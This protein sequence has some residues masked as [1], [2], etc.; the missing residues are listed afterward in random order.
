MDFVALDEDPCRKWFD[1]ESGQ[2]RGGRQQVKAPGHEGEHRF[3]LNIRVTADRALGMLIRLRSLSHLPALL[4]C[5]RP[6]A[7][8]GEDMRFTVVMA[9]S[10][11]SGF[12][13]LRD[14]I[15]L[16]IKPGGSDFFFEH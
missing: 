12:K 7:G 11:E 2:D 10:V 14:R 3:P 4:F 15:D 5:I 1:L 16:H 13:N 9:I 8:G 6:L